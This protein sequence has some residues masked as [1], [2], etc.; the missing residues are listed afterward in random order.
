M[1]AA[2][3]WDQA[4]NIILPYAA[5]HDLDGFAL[6]ARFPALTLVFALWYNALSLK[7]AL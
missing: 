3:L 4:G 7:M 5:E 6:C 2:Y 1:Q